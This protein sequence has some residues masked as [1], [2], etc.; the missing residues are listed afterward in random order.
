LDQ[1]A[2]DYVGNDDKSTP[3]KYDNCL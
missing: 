1:S 3:S 2:I